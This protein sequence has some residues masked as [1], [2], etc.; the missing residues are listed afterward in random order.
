[1]S[2]LF[3]A[4]GASATDEAKGLDRYWRNARTVLSH[5]PWVYK[6]RIVGDWL[7][8]GTGPVGLWGV[9]IPEDAKTAAQPVG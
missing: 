8:N 3:D 1:M 5:N 6:A 7:V 2:R 9:G 4:L